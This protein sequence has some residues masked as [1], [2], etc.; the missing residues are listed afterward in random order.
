[1]YVILT[2]D[3]NGMPKGTVSHYNPA[4]ITIKGKYIPAM[5]YRKVKSLEGEFIT[6]LHTAGTSKL[7]KGQTLQV[8]G[9]ELDALSIAVGSERI[10]WKIPS[11]LCFP[12]TI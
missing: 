6:I 2:K 5:H 3:F 11:F 4:G 1:M 9:H 12:V 8:L 10:H 7:K